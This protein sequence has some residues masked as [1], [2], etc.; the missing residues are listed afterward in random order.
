MI[1]TVML[2]NLRIL[3]ALAYITINN[4]EHITPHYDHG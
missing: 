2:I 4:P 1:I 3:I